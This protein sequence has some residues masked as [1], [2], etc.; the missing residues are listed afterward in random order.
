MYCDSEIKNGGENWLKKHPITR[1]HR[2]E[3]YVIAE[4]HGHMKT[5]VFEISIL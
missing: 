5:S 2:I 1:Y 3:L 4:S